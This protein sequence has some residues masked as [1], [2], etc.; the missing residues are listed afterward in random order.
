MHRDLN[1][2][3]RDWNNTLF[4]KSNDDGVAFG[5]CIRVRDCN[6]TFMLSTNDFDLHNKAEAF[7]K[8]HRSENILPA[9]IDD[10]EDA[11]RFIQEFAK[12]NE[13]IPYSNK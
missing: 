12:E 11:F 2:G 3:L 13:L 4:F 7:L 1:I 6:G 5:C 10:P 9:C 8:E